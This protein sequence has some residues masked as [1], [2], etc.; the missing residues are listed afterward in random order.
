MAFTMFAIIGALAVVGSVILYSAKFAATS[1]H[2]KAYESATA[3][4]KNKIQWKAAPPAIAYTAAKFYEMQTKMWPII[5]EIWPDAD[6]VLADKG[7]AYA[8]ALA[9][10]VLAPYTGRSTFENR[11]V[12]ALTLMSVVIFDENLQA[13]IMGAIATNKLVDAAAEE[14][15]REQMPLNQP[16]IEPN[17]FGRFIKERWIRSPWIH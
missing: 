1:E 3:G 17:D 13:R 8:F 12:H 9:E 14:Y 11:F 4:P 7:E 5:R 16:P 2:W 6:Q 10:A 15:I